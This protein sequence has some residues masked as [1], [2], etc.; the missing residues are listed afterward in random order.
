MEVEPQILNTSK[1]KQL[2]KD[3]DTLMKSTRSSSE[4][5]IKSA[6][7]NSTCLKKSSSGV[8]S[9]LRIKT[10]DSLINSDNMRAEHINFAT[11]RL[12]ADVDVSICSLEFSQSKNFGIAI[13]VSI[14]MFTI[15]E[16][17]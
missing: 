5:P 1:E 3:G 13:H 4:I 12:Q 15:L 17:F 6:T 11:S 14:S 8:N 2:D 9:R 10:S 7:N 16:T